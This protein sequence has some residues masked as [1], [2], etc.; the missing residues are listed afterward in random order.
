MELGHRSNGT[1]AGLTPGTVT[2]VRADVSS[3]CLEFAGNFVAGPS[4][5]PAPGACPR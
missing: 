3:Y 2:V 1:Y 4:G 5:I